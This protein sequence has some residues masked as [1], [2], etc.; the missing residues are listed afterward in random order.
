MTI[1][2][3]K[4]FPLSVSREDKASANCGHS[5]LL[6]WGGNLQTEDLCSAAKQH[7]NTFSLQL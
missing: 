2:Y 4:S 5:I 3:S 6:A 7:P 1:R